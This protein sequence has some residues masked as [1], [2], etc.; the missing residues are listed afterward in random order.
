MNKAEIVFEKL[1]LSNTLILETAKKSRKFVKSITGSDYRPKS[2]EEFRK[3]QDH[4]SRKINQRDFFERSVKG[5]KLEKPKGV[6]WLKNLVL[7]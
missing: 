5:S 3:I 2:F 7:K 6:A 4:W 1:A